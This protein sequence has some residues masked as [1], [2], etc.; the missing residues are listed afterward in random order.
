MHIHGDR[1]FV[2]GHPTW[3]VLR[4]A[5]NSVVLFLYHLRVFKGNCTKATIQFE[6]FGSFSS[7]SAAENVKDRN[8][9]PRIY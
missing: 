3:N 4:N 7:V 1:Q 5:W 2:E 6:L 9:I 8:R